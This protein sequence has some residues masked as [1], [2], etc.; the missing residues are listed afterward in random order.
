[1]IRVPAAIAAIT[2]ERSA[3]RLAGRAPR[4]AVMNTPI[5]AWTFVTLNAGAEISHS[6]LAGSWLES[7]LTI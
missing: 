4:I 7:G 5:V 3:F 6:S 2:I 1:M